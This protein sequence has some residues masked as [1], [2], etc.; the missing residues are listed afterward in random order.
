MN[1]HLSLGLNIIRVIA[2][3]T[4]FMLHSTIFEP[5]IYELMSNPNL[6]FLYPSA[7]AGVWIFFVIGGFLAGYS[8][9]SGKYTYSM[10]GVLTYYRKR[11]EKTIVPTVCF[12]LFCYL[13]VYTVDINEFLTVII[14][15][16]TFRYK[17][18]PGSDGISAT[19][20][21]ST[22]LF[23]Y[24]ISPAVCYLFEKIRCINENLP[25]YLLPILIILGA[26]F[27]FFAYKYQLDWNSVVYTPWYFNIDL[28][29]GGIIVAYCPKCNIRE[30]YS[31]LFRYVTFIVLIMVVLINAF[32]QRKMVF[33]ADSNSAV[34]CL[35]GFQSI[36]LIIISLF[37]FSHQCEDEQY[38]KH[39]PLIEKIIKRASSI[40]FEFYLFHSLVLHLW[41]AYILS[42]VDATKCGGHFIYLIIVALI[43]IILSYGYHK[44]FANLSQ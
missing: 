44:I 23:F 15:F 3:L 30:V 27:R 33:E 13:M 16:I 5:Q 21:V 32:F 17:G 7:W 11:L 35:Y 34:L 9:S 14:K 4:V 12:I 29:L 28:F 2:C 8:F 25:L 36:Y 43:T 10:N 41:S 18:I 19:W 26:I 6:F 24:I 1:K 22:L 42:Y 38:S 39:F 37:I 31:K 40:T 20:Y